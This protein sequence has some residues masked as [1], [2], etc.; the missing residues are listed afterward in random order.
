MKITM[1]T[2]ELTEAIEYYFNKVV[3]VGGDKEVV[4]VETQTVTQV[5]MFSFTVEPKKKT[6]AETT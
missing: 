1:D 6:S 5:P 4:K 3:F 2:M